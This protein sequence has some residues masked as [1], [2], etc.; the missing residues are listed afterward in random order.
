MSSSHLLAWI[1]YVPNEAGHQSKLPLLLPSYPKLA[2][3]FC[4]CKKSPKC[5]GYNDFHDRLHMARRHPAKI[6]SPPSSAR[7]PGKPHTG[8]LGHTAAV[9]REREEVGGARIEPAHASR[10]KDHVFGMDE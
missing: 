7:R 3:Y 10:G 6:A 2:Q 1:I 9:A 8:R 5:L 4:L